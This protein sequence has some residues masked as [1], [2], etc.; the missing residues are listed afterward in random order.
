MAQAMLKPE[1][2]FCDVYVLRD[3]RPVWRNQRSATKAKSRKT[4]VTVQPAMK[5]GLSPKAPTS[6]MYAIF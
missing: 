6:E 5:S 4:V 3:S 2:I 1:R